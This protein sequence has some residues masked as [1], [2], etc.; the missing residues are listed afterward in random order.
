MIYSK[1]PQK[2]KID[3]GEDI[4]HFRSGI[5]SIRYA[6]VGRETT[7]MICRKLDVGKDMK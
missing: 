7:P 3:D 1:G 5:E 6:T 4:M 2:D